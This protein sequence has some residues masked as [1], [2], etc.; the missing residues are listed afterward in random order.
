MKRNR[1]EMIPRLNPHGIRQQASGKFPGKFI[2][3]KDLSDTLI[4]AQVIITDFYTK[5]VFPTLLESQ[6]SKFWITKGVQK[7]NWVELT[8]KTVSAYFQFKVLNE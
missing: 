4:R 3:V 7:D 5:R 6:K 1:E 8:K 2:D